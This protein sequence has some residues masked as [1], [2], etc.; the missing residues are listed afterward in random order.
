MYPFVLNHSGV[1][2]CA[3]SHS[4]DDDGVHHLC[5]YACVCTHVCKVHTCINRFAGKRA[6]AGQR[7]DRNDEGS[8]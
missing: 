5:M 8:D 3:C 1:R 4:D 6:V 7:K 2:A